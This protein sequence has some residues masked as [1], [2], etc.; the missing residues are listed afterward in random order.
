M[1]AD[2]VLWE[3][4]RA[5]VERSDFSEFLSQFSLNQLPH[6]RRL[7]Q[8][9]SSFEFCIG[10]YDDDPREIYSIPEIR[11]FYRSFHATWPYWL[12][13]CMTDDDAEGLK[14]MMFC[15]LDSFATLH[16]DGRDEVK[17]EYE[18]EELS[19][20]VRADFPMMIEVCAR[21]EMLDNLIEQRRRAVL[22]Y[23]NLP[24]DS[25]Q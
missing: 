14:N 19:A 2:L 21:A 25:A 13:F 5:K 10:G 9:M 1:N 6:G 12:Y 11:D 7:R 24:E 8:M 18:A 3:F 17:I 20:L 16:V 4:T 15:R 23:F 22:N